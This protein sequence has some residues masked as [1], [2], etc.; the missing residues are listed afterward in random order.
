MLKT[1]LC[2]LEAN[3]SSVSE[4]PCSDNLA[5]MLGRDDLRLLRAA[6]RT[7]VVTE[8]GYL[9]AYGKQRLGRAG[10]MQG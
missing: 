1:I 10:V 4:S 6:I 7:G 9:T 5:G 3:K 8:G 2:L